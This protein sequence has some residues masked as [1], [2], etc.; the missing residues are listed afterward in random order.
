MSFKPTQSGIVTCQA[1]NTEG[2]AESNANI[3]FGDM[4]D[5]FMVWGINSEI[6]EGDR[7][8]LTCGASKYRYSPIEWYYN[9]DKL[10]EN[11]G[12]IFKQ[13]LS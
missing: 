12:K 5:D 3:V 8:V 10:V 4:N 13:I 6:A 7:I 2:P 11:Q 9:S 1:R